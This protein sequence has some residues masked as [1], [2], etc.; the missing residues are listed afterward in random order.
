MDAL[1]GAGFDPDK[2]TYVLW[3]GVTMYLDADAVAETLSDFARLAPGSR[4]AFD[5]FAAELVDHE[6]PHALLGRLMPFAMWMTYGERITYG[7]P[8]QPEARP[9]LDRFLGRFG[10]ETLEFETVGDGSLYGFVLARGL[11]AKV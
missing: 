2:P 3:E 1:I 9:A 6:S 7:I 11:P 10:L 8:M 4:I 5:Y